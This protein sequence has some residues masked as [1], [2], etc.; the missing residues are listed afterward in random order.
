MEATL[1]RWEEEE[2]ALTKGEPECSTFGKL[3]QVEN[4]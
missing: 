1:G 2:H 4:K 3:R